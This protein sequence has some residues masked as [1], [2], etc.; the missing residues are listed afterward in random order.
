MK[1]KLIYSDLNN[2]TNYIVDQSPKDCETYESKL[3][4]HSIVFLL[5]RLAILCV[6]HTHT[7]QHFASYN[8]EHRDSES[9]VSEVRPFS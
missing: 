1:E 7:Y 6:S 2:V 5:K 8:S 4:L 3:D 9:L